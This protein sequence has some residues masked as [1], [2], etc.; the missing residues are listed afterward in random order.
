M[1]KLAALVLGAMMILGLAACNGGT[2]PPPAEEGGTSY[3]IAIVKQLDHASLDEIANAV[4]AQLDT[5]AAERG[6]TITYKVFSGQNDSTLLNQI[7]SQ[8]VSEEYDAIIPIA[9]LAAQAMAT[10]AEATKTPVI[11][12][13]ISDPEE[14]GL[15]DLDYVTGLSDALD[16]QKI[17]DMMLAQ[18]PD[19]QKVGLLYSLSEPNSKKPIEQA[20]AYLDAKGIAYQE[21]TGSNNEEIITAAGSLVGKVDAIFTPTDNVVMGA[22]LT[23]GEILAG[24]GIPHYAGADSFVRNGAFA[25]CGVNYTDLGKETAV[26]AVDLLESG[27]IPAYKVMEGGIITVN[28]ET[29]TTLGA[30]YSM[31]AN[32]GTVVEVVTTEE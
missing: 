10:A 24:A 27:S 18:N 30:D 6:I 20:K 16:T 17:M 25:T 32:L 13:A 5:L 3:N 12:A 11:F 2:T 9:T 28:T 14:A 15:V 29:A 1:K 31:F 23:I 19:I 21:A 4:A 26:M 7:G 22:E 8:I